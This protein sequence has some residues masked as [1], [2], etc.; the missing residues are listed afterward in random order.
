MNGE[1]LVVGALV[2][3]V[4]FGWLMGQAAADVKN[5]RSKAM[6]KMCQAMLCRQN[7]SGYEMDDECKA[8]LEKVLGG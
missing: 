2:T 3:G 1:L 7:M 6:K 8:V 5:V 4:V